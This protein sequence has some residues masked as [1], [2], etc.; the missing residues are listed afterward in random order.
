MFR[1]SWLDSLRYKSFRDIGFYV[2]CYRTVTRET[3]NVMQA[4]DLEA[5]ECIAQG[6]PSPKDLEVEFN[7]FYLDLVNAVRVSLYRILELGLHL[8]PSIRILDIGTG[9]GVFPFCCQ[10]YGHEVVCTDVDDNPFFNEVT[11]LLGVDR[12]VWRV[13]CFEPAPDFGS[14]FDLVTATNVGFNRVSKPTNRRKSGAE[15]SVP[16][17]DFFLMDLA[18]RVATGQGRV[19]LTLNT[20]QRRKRDVALHEELL[21]F[22][23]DRG[24]QLPSRGRIVFPSLAR[25]QEPQPDGSP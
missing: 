21:K 13:E 14:R 8:G 9:P 6:Y 17:W 23:T 18:R 10:H 16:E 24:G 15:W 2:R 19:F 1:K 25:F 4:I 5:F 12:R 3:R 11:Q 20:L 22:F 7:P